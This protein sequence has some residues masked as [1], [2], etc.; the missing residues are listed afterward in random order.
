[1]AYRTEDFARENDHEEPDDFVLP[2]ERLNL[3]ADYPKKV[4]QVF[5][6][7]DLETLSLRRENA[8]GLGIEAY[9]FF[10]IAM[11]AITFI[12]FMGM[13]QGGQ[14]AQATGSVAVSRAISPTTNHFALLWVIGI[15]AL[16]VGVPLYIKKAYGAA[17]VFTFNKASGYLL[18]NGKRVVSLRRIEGIAIRETKDPDDRYLYL[19][20]VLHTDGY[21]LL[22]YNGY[23]ERDAMTLATEIAGFL[24]CRVK[25]T[26]VK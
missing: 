14:A 16:A 5:M 18:E 17:L 9:I 21:E 2:L 8:G 7:R 4:G 10:A 11:V 25:Y 15:A 24:D 20:E 6:E 23:E 1:M 19:L 26:G 22:L 13:M 3:Y 12:G